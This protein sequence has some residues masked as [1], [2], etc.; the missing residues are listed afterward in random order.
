MDK[1]KIALIKLLLC[2]LTGLSLTACSGRLSLPIATVSLSPTTTIQS[3]NQAILTIHLTG[4]AQGLVTFH[5]SSNGINISPSSCTIASGQSCQMTVST[6]FLQSPPGK[7]SISITS[8][9]NV[10]INPENLDFN[11]IPRQAAYSYIAADN[12]EENQGSIYRCTVDANGL[13]D[14]CNVVIGPSLSSDIGL[15][16]PVGISFHTLSNGNTYAYIANYSTATSGENVYRCLADSQGGLSSCVLT[17]DINF[18]VSQ[19]GPAYIAFNTAPSGITY[20][21]VPSAGG[22]QGE[23]IYRCSINSVNGLLSSCQATAQDANI[24]SPVVMAF[25]TASNGTT[26]AYV[27]AGTGIN[28]PGEVYRCQVS[29]DGLLNSC[30]SELNDIFFPTGIAFNTSVS[31]TTYAYIGSLF[32]SE[33]GQ[34][35]LLRCLVND[36]GV[37]TGC[38]S[39]GSNLPLMN[40]TGIAFNTTA[41]N[42]RYVYIT[43]NVNVTGEQVY[44]CIIGANGFIDNCQSAVNDSNFNF[45]GFLPY[46]MSFN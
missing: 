32:N 43:D 20:A 46:L 9:A 10:T 13:F 14:S 33:E 45:G 23:Q 26:Y 38:V 21:Y 25:N 36:S 17:T 1:G 12:G 3:G 35:V 8:S 39:A 30:E 22:E 5:A 31:G 2:V 16:L 42:A 24:I 29:S 11:I 19:L 6:D 15:D 27:T 37:L 41:S 4:D 28:V 34:P 7:H 40:T 44:R 18:P